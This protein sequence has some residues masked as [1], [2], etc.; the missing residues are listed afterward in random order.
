MTSVHVPVLAGELIEL[1]DPQPGDVA[2]DCTF[3]G[4][5]HARLVAD[6][7]GPQ[8]TLIAIDRDPVA[9]ERFAELAAEVPCRTRFI[10]A[11]FADALEQLRDEG[12]T[13]DVLYMDLGISS[14]QV[15]TL[16][17]GFSYVY[18]AP[19]DMRMDPAQELTAAGLVGEW[20]ERQLARLFRDYGEE[21]YAPQIAPAI[22]RERARRPIATTNDLVDVITAAVP[23]PAR[24]GGGHPAKRVFQAIRI[25]V[26]EELDQLDRALPLAWEILRPNAR[27]AGISFHSLEDRRV[28]RFL[29]ARAQGCICPPDLPV[30][31]CGRVPEAELLTRRAVAP[32]PGEIAHNPRAK[33]ARMRVARKLEA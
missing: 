9:E 20:D 5:G 24:F 14:M 28:K 30:C 23:A 18:D 4:G 25:A 6:R 21:R 22:V 19:L 11:A 7:L 13:A 15:D 3:G 31:R 17:R 32:T 29:A 27:F 10:H 2:I 12:V 26:N 1:L 33:S 16:E 8:G